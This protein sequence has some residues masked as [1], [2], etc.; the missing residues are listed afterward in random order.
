MSEKRRDGSEPGAGP[1]IPGI[2][3]R[4]P[5]SW[6]DAGEMR[7]RAR[8]RNAV[9]LAVAAS[10]LLLFVLLIHLLLEKTRGSAGPSPAAMAL[11]PR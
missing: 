4:R 7:R 3:G 6:P 2:A 10:C 8:R 5:A 9:H 11:M 1:T